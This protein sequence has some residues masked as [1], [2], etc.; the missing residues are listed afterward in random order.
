MQFERGPM[1][2]RIT[3]RSNGQI[4]GLFILVRTPPDKVWRVIANTL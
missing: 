4:A 1:K 2:S 3:L